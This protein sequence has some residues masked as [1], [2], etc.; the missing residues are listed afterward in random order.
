MMA[1]Q[2]ILLLPIFIPLI[3]AAVIFCLPEKRG[4]V[5]RA[6][7]SL[8]VILNFIA[9]VIL[10]NK[11]L[12]FILPWLGF[13]IDFSL[14]GYFFANFIVLAI[15]FFALVI[16]IYT[17]SFLR[18]KDYAG[19]FLA[20]TLIAV[21]FTQ[22]AVLSDNLVLLLFFWESLLVVML[23]MIQAA[24]RQAFKTAIKMFIIVGL[25]DLCM[26][27]GI[28]L[29]GKIAGTL[30]ISGQAIDI[31]GWGQ[32]A[33]ILLLIGALSKAGAMPFHTW[34]PD[35]AS[36]AP[37]PF[38]A[39][40]PAALEKLLG[41]YF[42]TRLTLGMFKPGADSWIS[43][44]LMAIG[45]ITIILAVMMALV[46][47]NYK[48]LLAYHAVS[49]VGYM[50]LGVGTLLPAGVIG[51]LFHML[52]NALYKSCLFLTGGAVERQAGSADL[53]ELGGLGRKMP[54]TFI[55]FI[56]TAASISGVPPF[57]GFIS[58]ELIYESVK[59]RGLIFYV[60]AI[61]GSFFTAASFLKLGHSV[62]LGKVN[63]RH[64]EVKEAPF[65]TLMPMVIIA[66][67]C[68]VFGI[69]NSLPIRIFF[70]PALEASR[71]G[72]GSFEGFRLNLFLSAVTVVTLL[73]ALLNHVYGVKKS[74]RT[75]GALDHI[76]Y[77]PGLKPLYRLAEKGYFDPY[78]IG[79]ALANVIASALMFFDR[80]IN[81]FYDNVVV[82]LT[83]IL[84][85]L[86][87]RSHTGNYSFYIAC[88]IAAATVV[89]VF[90]LNSMK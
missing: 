74:G 31:A 80:V 39:L 1:E 56:I 90:M 41:I 83:D 16:G 27:L 59:S 37:L 52:N 64:E 2:N 63:K 5:K 33:F 4:N 34:I 60:F 77:A 88:S 78:N 8:G 3:A 6:V 38:M 72:I 75:A 67:L 81:F 45:G 86:L 7:F 44:V 73:A 46:Q 50:V 71:F 32:A 35:A 28:A 12:D 58:K 25:C 19:F 85:G 68:V 61:L 76:R 20:C 70:K 23:A 87:R 18:G 24:G 69:F 48:R 53:E 82:G 84:A 47:K 51:G 57:N 49:Q 15:A 29:Y 14:R 55:C 26:M 79:M 13:G 40:I 11:R 89:V 54:V 9:A 65:Y 66:F 22:G 36:D 21:S 42:L 43:T 30:S 10:F 62:Y 17:L